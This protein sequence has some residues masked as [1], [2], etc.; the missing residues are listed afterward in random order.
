[1]LAV[2]SF[3]FRAYAQTDTRP[4]IFDTE[5]PPEWYPQVNP[6]NILA[7]MVG[8]EPPVLDHNGKPHKHGHIVQLIMDGGNGLQDPPNP[9]GSPG[10][11][12]S[13]A[14]GNFNMIRFL[15][16]EYPPDMTAATGI[17]FSKRYFIP[18]VKNRALY[19]RVWEGEDERVAP[20][21]QNSTEYRSDEDQGGAMVNLSDGVPV[22]YF[23]KFGPS[24]PRPKKK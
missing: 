9:D 12:D 16:E 18:F 19:L 23:W 21:Y 8:G 15:G 17:F 10:G 3:V 5:P 1:M 24:I 14:Y 6:F 13:L 7:L 22:D 2:A 4:I 20:Y 11:D